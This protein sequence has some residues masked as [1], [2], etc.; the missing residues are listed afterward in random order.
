MIFAFTCTRYWC[1][2][3]LILKSLLVLGQLSHIGHGGSDGYKTELAK[4][5]TITFNIQMFKNMTITVAQR[6]KPLS[7]P[8][9]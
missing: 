8:V 7:H 3:I 1:T 9:L 5:Y 4:K 6:A 2:G